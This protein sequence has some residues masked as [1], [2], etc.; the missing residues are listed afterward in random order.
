MKQNIEKNDYT[1]LRKVIEKTEG[2]KA[3][4]INNNYQTEHFNVGLFY[5][6]I[7]TYISKYPKSQENADTT[8]NSN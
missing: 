3:I 4:R 7:S 6:K 8:N 2:N 5:K 1:I